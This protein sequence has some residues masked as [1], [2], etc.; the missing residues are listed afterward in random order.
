[1]WAKPVTVV[2]PAAEPI[3]LA[4]AKQFLRLDEDE[5]GFD[6]E[7]GILIAGARGDVEAVTSSRMVLQTVDIA[8][9]SFD[10]LDR[11]SVGPVTE[12]VSVAYRD[13]NGHEQSIP[14]E[15]LELF[16]AVLEQGVRMAPGS[17][18]PIALRVKG[19]VR[20]RVIVGYG[21]NGEGI[22][23]AVRT[24]L[25]LQIRAL[26]DGGEID[27]DRWVVNDRIWL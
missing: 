21:E 8:A 20:V 5:V 24:G 9:D 23:D 13:R 17:R 11:L 25:L 4:Q 6:A 15:D 14:L 19:A 3:S 10:D 7:L 16:G 1:M 18:W 2:P 27:L 22:P 26:F 12:L